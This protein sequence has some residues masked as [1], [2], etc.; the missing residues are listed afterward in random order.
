MKL[1][2]LGCSHH[3]SSLE[4]REQLAFA[5]HQLGDALRT[6]QQQFPETEAVLLSTCNRVE[7]YVAT[8][9]LGTV[10]DR[11]PLVAFLANYHQL[12]ADTLSRELYYYQGRE[13]VRHLFLVAASLDSMV[14][15]EA[16]ILSQ[17]KQA[18]AAAEQEQSHGPVTHHVFQ[19]AYRVAKRVA[20]ETEISRR[21]VSIPSIAVAE[22]A[23]Q[24]F[25]TFQD[26]NILLLGAGE[27]GE[28]T[29]RYLKDEGAQTV[30]ILNRNPKRAELLAEKLDAFVDD[31]QQ[32]EN[33]I[34]WADLIVSTTASREPIVTLEQFET[35]QRQRAERLLFILDLAVPRDFDPRIGQFSNVYLYCIDNLQAVCDENRKAREKEWPKAERIVDEETVRCVSDW[36]HRATAP[37]IQRLHQQAE[38]VK[39]DELQR[40][41]NKLRDIDPRSQ[42]EI[43]H[44]FDRLTKKLLHPPLE[45]LRDEARKGTPHSLL[46]A[47][48]HLFQISE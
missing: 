9:D 5:P 42:E 23:K 43:K 4:L 34:T 26:K 38:Q 40:L 24:L 19:A 25:E 15:G 8:S 41:L 27:M 30:A 6:L 11:E 32:L 13:A 2:L 7:L 1:Q 10:P 31:W 47:L 33:R 28:E 36:Y 22:Y 16:Q 12:D 35:V 3:A 14:V 21:R 45:S 39:N 37:T 48:R 44:S 20:N 46:A 29:L 18:F 17:V